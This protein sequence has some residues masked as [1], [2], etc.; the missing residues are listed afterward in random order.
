MMRL[1]TH[2]E[3]MDIADA[4]VELLQFASLNGNQLF[5]VD[6]SDG[7]YVKGYGIPEGSR[8][9]YVAA[10]DSLT[11]DGSVTPL[12]RNNEIQ[13]FSIT[14]FAASM[15]TL[16]SAKERILQEMEEYGYVYKIHS[17]TGEFVQ[18]VGENFEQVEY[19]RI[20]FMRALGDL[21]HS[22]QIDVHSDTREMCIYKKSFYSVPHSSN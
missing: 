2:G 18:F 20:L 15:V 9:L 13:L 1:K 19:S 11:H 8:D 3:S 22:G 17:H 16:D 14:N 5:K 12:F 10:L 7:V 21:L 4:R 6:A